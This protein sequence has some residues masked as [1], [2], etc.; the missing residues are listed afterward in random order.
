MIFRIDLLKGRGIPAKTRPVGLAITS[1]TF[2][3]PVI[4]AIAMLG[5]YLHDRI[6]IS[7][8]RQATAN[9][10]E[11]IDELFDAV[12]VCKSFEKTRDIIND[13]LS[14]VSSSIIRHTQWSP[15]LATI[16]KNIPDSAALTGLEV[17]R[18]FVKRRTGGED[19]AAEAAEITVPVNRLQMDVIANSRWDGDGAVRDFRERLRF[20]SILGPKLE[21][22][23]VSQKTDTFNGRDV[24]S[25]K[26]DCI[27]K[28]EL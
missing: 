12:E 16:A 24:V 15:V 17:R 26:M 13:C 3:V 28:P 10:E 2:A 8:Q 22:I 25:Y 4:I 21:D 27:F 1:V 7:V 14:E 5:S 20:S 6:T 18:H 11:K 19:A 23:R 9:Y